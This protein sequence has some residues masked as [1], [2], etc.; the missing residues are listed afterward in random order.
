M[1]SLICYKKQN[2]NS[3]YLVAEYNNN[4]AHFDIYIP[5]YYVKK[6]KNQIKKV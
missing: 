5:V 1:P 2:I 6:K 3:C 4:K